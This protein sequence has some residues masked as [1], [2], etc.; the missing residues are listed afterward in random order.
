MSEQPNAVA[1][2]LQDMEAQ[3]DRLSVEHP[4]KRLLWMAA[5]VIIAQQQL[6]VEAQPQPE[7]PRIVVP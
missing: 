3:F 6:L 2:L 5:N 7:Q 4:C 1:V